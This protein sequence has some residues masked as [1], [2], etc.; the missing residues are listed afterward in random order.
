MRR[1]TCRYCTLRDGVE[2]RS[3][4]RLEWGDESLDFC[5]FYCLSD[6][7]DEREARLEKRATA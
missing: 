4:I 2:Q 3:W 7:T 5:S 1:R 6:W